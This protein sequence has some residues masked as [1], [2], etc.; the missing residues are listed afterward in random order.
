MNVMA[1]AAICATS[2]GLGAAALLFAPALLDRPGA[3]HGVV[4]ESPRPAAVAITVEVPEIGDLA[5]AVDTPVA[6]PPSFALDLTFASAPL[7]PGFIDGSPV[8]SADLGVAREI[9]SGV[10]ALR[11]HRFESEDVPAVEG[12][13]LSGGAAQPALARLAGST[14]LQ[15]RPPL[16]PA[17]SEVAPSV[18]AAP[19]PLAEP[20]RPTV[21][22]N[23]P[24]IA[25]GESAREFAVAA[26]PVPPSTL[27]LAGGNKPFLPISP[28]AGTLTGRTSPAGIASWYGPGFHGRRTASGERFNQND[29]TAA[30]PHLPFGSR[31]RVVD[32]RSGRSIVVRI[33]DRGPFKPGRII[34]LS[35]ASAQA[36][37]M[38][39]LARVKLVSAE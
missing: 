15:V 19:E 8:F 10:G 3:G 23:L 32:E 20:E 27:P 5:I 37:G 30:H 34:D 28:F 16:R 24:S 12:P 25:G 6:L 26:S 7:R 22:A 18:S 2:A 31:V 17:F 39:G 29:M 1:G 21:L 33:N 4:S 14:I 9:P 13:P 11:L 35:K 38:G 36:L